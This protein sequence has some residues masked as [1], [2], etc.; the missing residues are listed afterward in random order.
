M[1]KERQKE[2]YDVILYGG[3]YDC[4]LTAK[5][6]AYRLKTTERGVR[7]IVSEL[8]INGYPV[9]SD[10]KGYWAAASPKDMVDTVRRIKSH[11]LKE[12]KAIS[13]M[14]R[15]CREAGLDV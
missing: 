8:R 5:N 1:T 15:A 9:C 12:L 7:D 3:D 10:S 13:R 4:P 11:A 6:L 2:C 14:L